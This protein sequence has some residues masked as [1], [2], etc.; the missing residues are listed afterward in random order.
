LTQKIRNK[1]SGG[2]KRNKKLQIPNI[3][4][5]ANK[6]HGL[7]LGDVKEGSDI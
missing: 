4:D 2:Y 3:S 6:N 7:F 1:T 5:I